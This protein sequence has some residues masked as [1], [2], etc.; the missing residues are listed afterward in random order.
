MSI[1]VLVADPDEAL[2]VE[3]KNS[4]SSYQMMVFTATNGFDCLKMLRADL[5][6]VLVLE[7]DLPCEQAKLLVDFMRDSSHVPTVPVIV[8]SHHKREQS[9]IPIRFPIWAYYSKPIAM[10][11]LAN[12]IRTAAQQGPVKK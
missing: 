12:V 9:P 10:D 7:F 4:L 1:R 3:Y 2:L 5:P 8:V 11:E 6:Q